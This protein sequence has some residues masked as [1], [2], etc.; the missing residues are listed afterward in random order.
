MKEPMQSVCPL[1]PPPILPTQSPTVV[2]PSP[3]RTPIASTSE[4]PSTSPTSIP[5]V[6]PTPSCPPIR[7]TIGNDTSAIELQ[8]VSDSSMPKQKQMKKQSLHIF[9]DPLQ[10]DARGRGVG[11]NS[12][13]A[14]PSECPEITTIIPKEKDDSP[15]NE[16]ST[17]PMLMKKVK[18][19]VE[20]KEKLIRPKG[21][22]SSKDS[23]VDSY[24]SDD[25]LSFVE[26]EKPSTS[27]SEAPVTLGE[28]NRGSSFGSITPSNRPTTTYERLET[29]F[30][31]SHEGWNNDKGTTFTKHPP[32]MTEKNKKGSR[33]RR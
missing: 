8:P 15:V 12:P 2:K 4:Q 1:A 16:S 28:S 5:S 33:F 22:A 6:I 9:Y 3:T 32:S 14:P 13:V 26:I 30:K 10:Y 23:N 7:K 17:K 27:P 11:T 25:D 31:M 21:D 20:M 29:Q 18:S 24:G 19:K